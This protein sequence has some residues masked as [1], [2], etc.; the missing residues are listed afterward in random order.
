MVM[1]NLFVHPIFNEIKEVVI[2]EG[3]VHKEGDSEYNEAGVYVDQYLSRFECDSLVTTYLEVANFHCS[4]Y[5]PNAITADNDG[6]NET[7]GIEYD[8]NFYEYDLKI[9]DRWGGLVFHSNDPDARWIGNGK[10]GS[11]Y[12]AS[13]GMYSYVLQYS[14][15]DGDDNLPNG[16]FRI[17][18]SV[19]VIR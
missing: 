1:T 17:F 10:E 7:F 13:D 8:C 18:G 15:I 12:Y 2:C 19:T 6:I 9:Y 5:A 16:P 3:E 14:S 11:D 4:I